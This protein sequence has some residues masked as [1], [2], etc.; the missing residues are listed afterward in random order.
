M[1]S[2]NQVTLIGNVGKEPMSHAS[3][4][5]VGITTFSVATSESWKNKNTGEKNVSTDWHSV[6]CFGKLAEIATLYIK[7]GSKIFI[8]GKL[9]NK[10]WVDKNNIERSMQQIMCENFILL[11]KPPENGFN[12]IKNGNVAHNSPTDD[13]I[14]F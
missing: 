3:E 12:N 13:D 1:K 5:G 2:L 14:P 8:Q 4:S 10:S 11:D 6:V 7:K 9:K